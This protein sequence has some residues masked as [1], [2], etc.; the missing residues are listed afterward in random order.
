MDY[1]PVDSVGG[2]GFDFNGAPIVAPISVGA[3]SINTIS[4]RVRNEGPAFINISSLSAAYNQSTPLAPIAPG[5]WS[6][7]PLQQGSVSQVYAVNWVA[8]GAPGVYG[9]CVKADWGTPQAFQE[10]DETNNEFCA[11]VGVA[12]P[13]LVP[14]PVFVNVAGV[15]APGSPFSWQVGCPP[16]A[17]SLTDTVEIRAIVSNVLPY[18]TGTSNITVAMYNMTGCGGSRIG[19]PFFL[20]SNIP[21]IPGMGMSGVQIANWPAPGASGTFWIS[22]DVDP[23]PP[24]N[25]TIP[26]AD[27][28]NNTLTFMI[29]VPGPDLVVQPVTI[30]TGSGPQP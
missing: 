22:V 5:P 9:V 1:V 3:G 21:P 15:P 7:A 12:L 24:A 10:I 18:G 17:V 25:G 19:A 26:E 11:D 23:P 30:D 29:V 27:E 6:T 2:I 28:G 8:P 20:N 13:D 16:I 14:Q 4:F